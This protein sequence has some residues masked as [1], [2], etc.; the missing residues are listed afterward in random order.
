MSPPAWRSAGA[1]AAAAVRRRRGSGWS[2]EVAF[3]DHWLATKGFNWPDDFR[4]KTDPRAKVLIPKWALP[5]A[6]TRPRRFLPG[7][8]PRLSILDV[9][10][11]PLSLVG[12]RLPGVDVELTAVDPLAEEYDALLRKHGIKPLTRVQPCPAEAVADVIGESRFDVVYSQNALD[13]TE[14]A[15][16]GLEQMVRVVKPGCWTVLKHTIDEAETESY[17]SLHDWNF[18]IEEGRF[19]IWNR[20]A[21]IFPDE[22]LGSAAVIV[23]HEVYEGGYSWILVG[24]QRRGAPA[25]GR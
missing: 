22:Q 21:R 1:E 19:L 3:W 6:T 7:Q 16:A 25:S 20:R 11:G 23:T 18:R 17:G 10:S 5:A 12:T 15:F 4:R 14:N 24:I 9:G 13:H 8:R 2:D